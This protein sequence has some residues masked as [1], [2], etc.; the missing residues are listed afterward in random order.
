MSIPI[1]HMEPKGR[2]FKQQTSTTQENTNM[3]NAS[4][5]TLHGWTPVGIV[6]LTIKG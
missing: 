6:F 4:P 1:N 3:Y 5:P 2:W